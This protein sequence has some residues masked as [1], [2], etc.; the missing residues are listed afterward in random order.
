MDDISEYERWL[1]NSGLGD[2]LNGE[3][4][5]DP[6]GDFGRVELRD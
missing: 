2:T 4:E 5:I 1:S 3:A 6:D